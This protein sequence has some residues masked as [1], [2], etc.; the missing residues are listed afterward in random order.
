MDHAETV[1][2]TSR[3]E[4]RTEMRETVLPR[5]AKCVNACMRALVGWLRFDE[6]TRGAFD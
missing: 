6:R 3:V 1:P 2:G 5:V 4:W